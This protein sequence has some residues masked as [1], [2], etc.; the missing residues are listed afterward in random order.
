MKKS[1]GRGNNSL[2]FYTE[3]CLFFQ[4]CIIIAVQSLHNYK[5]AFFVYTFSV[6]L[7]DSLFYL[8]IISDGLKLFYNFNNLCYLFLLPTL[9]DDHCKY[10][11]LFVL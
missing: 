4:K 2:V 1:N 3:R 5:T 10:S 7:H 8:K 6:C 9:R 11:M